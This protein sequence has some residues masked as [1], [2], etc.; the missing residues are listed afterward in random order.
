MVE[1]IDG[2]MKMQASLPSMHL[3]I[4]N[5]LAYPLR[6]NSEKTGL[7][8]ELRWAEVG[9]LYFEELKV[10][11]FPCFRLAIEAGRRG[12]TY[13]GALVGADEEAVQ[14]FLAGEISFLDI[15]ELIEAVLEHH[16][17]IEQPDVSATLEACSWARRMVHELWKK[18]ACELQSSVKEKGD[19]LL[20]T[21]D[22][23]IR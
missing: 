3:P 4:M 10:E 21:D 15:A 13:P 5:A 9:A 7:L 6:L 20:Y 17:S 23:P 16:H 2:S 18:R 11:R 8:C 12:G 14:L 1:F 22:Y 19:G